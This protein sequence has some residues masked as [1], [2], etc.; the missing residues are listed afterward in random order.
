[1][2]ILNDINPKT[3]KILSVDSEMSSTFYYSGTPEIKNY[4][5]N[6]ENRPLYCV[7]QHCTMICFGQISSNYSHALTLQHAYAKDFLKVW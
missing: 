6:K 1:M 4:F 2:Q 7:L 3:D 5:T